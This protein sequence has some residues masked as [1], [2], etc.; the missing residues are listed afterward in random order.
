MEP[1][2]KTVKRPAQRLRTGRAVVSLVLGTEVIPE[3]RMDP[4][5]PC[6]RGS[7][8]LYTGA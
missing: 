3:V 8:L 6:I 5:S 7:P 1:G 2:Q 4:T